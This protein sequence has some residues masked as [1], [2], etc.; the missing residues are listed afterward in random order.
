MQFAEN[1]YNFALNFCKI[2]SNIYKNFSACRALRSRAGM[3][4]K[5]KYMGKPVRFIKCDSEK[6]PETA[7]K[8]EV[9]LDEGDL[10][11]VLLEE[12]REVN[13][14]LQNIDFVLKI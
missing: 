4:M 1:F 12:E 10:Y 7:R 11:F 8:V 2:A 6:V 3:E 9:Y 13:P 5:E 14:F